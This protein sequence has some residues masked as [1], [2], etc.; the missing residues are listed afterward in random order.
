[1][2]YTV[3]TRDGCTL[4]TGSVPASQFNALL[5][6]ADEGSEFSDHLARLAGVQFAWG[7][8]ADVA[9]LESKLRAEKLAALESRQAAL[10]HVGLSDDARRWLA[11]GEQGRSSCAMF[12][13]FT[14]VKPD[15][16]AHLRDDDYPRDS[17]DLRRCL[18]LIDQVP[19]FRERVAEMAE[20]SPEWA[21]LVSAW[22]E[23]AGLMETECP[24]WRDPD[25]TGSA[26]KTYKLMRGVL[27]KAKEGQDANKN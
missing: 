15:Y 22:N 26:P 18:L 16:I 21:A 13:K 23:L 3:E 27:R 25:T 24:S 11:V 6:V 10:A 4:I 9:A 5:S 1:M 14:G 2:A 7:L 12:L 19:E 8:P 20:C 17:G